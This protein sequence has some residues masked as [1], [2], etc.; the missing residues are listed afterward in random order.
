[1]RWQVVY[2][3][4]MCCIA[5]AFV[6]ATVQSLASADRPFLVTEFDQ[7]KERIMGNQSFDL[8]Q[9]LATRSTQAKELLSAHRNIFTQFR[10]KV[11]KAEPFSIKEIVYEP[12]VF[13]YMGFIERSA[14]EVIAQIN[15]SS[16]T[17][18]VRVRETI[19]DWTVMQITSE[20]VELL[21]TQ[22]ERIVLPIQE[23][24]MS[25]KPYARVFLFSTEEEQ[26]ITIGDTVEGHKVLDITSDAVILT[27]DSGPLSIYK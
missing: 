14:S 26:K 19:Q 25:S 16:Q 20:K 22:G 21:S 2:G 11:I 18:F 10:Q 17:Y 5:L 1:M 9:K 13:M 15:W 4:I 23:K 27:T 6:V 12:F 3:A 8:I 24:I 7:N